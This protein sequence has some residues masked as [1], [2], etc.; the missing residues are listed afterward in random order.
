MDPHLKE[1]IIWRTSYQTASKKL[2]PSVFPIFQVYKHIYIYM[3]CKVY[4]HFLIVQKENAKPKTKWHFSLIDMTGI[5]T[6]DPEHLQLHRSEGHHATTWHTFDFSSPVIIPGFI[7]C[8]S[9]LVARFQLS[10]ASRRRNIIDQYLYV[11][12]FTILSSFCLHLCRYTAIFNLPQQFMGIVE[13]AIITF[14]GA[15]RHKYTISN[16]IY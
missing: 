13:A 10:R 9:A 16:F 7:N 8:N 4:T 15:P 12:L 1:F 2:N 11:T 14:I 6:T 3:S 5:E